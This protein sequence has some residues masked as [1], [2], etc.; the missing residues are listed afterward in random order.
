MQCSPPVKMHFRFSTQI[1][2]EESHRLSTV[3]G[4]LRA[5]LLLMGGLWDF[6]MGICVENRKC[7]LTCGQH[8]RLHFVPRKGFDDVP[9]T[10]Q[11]ISRRILTPDF[12]TGF[13]IDNKTDFGHAQLET[14]SGCHAHLPNLAESRYRACPPE[15]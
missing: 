15:V 10:S 6:P 4:I 7:I 2:M 1:P 8:C 5:Y 3:N 14:H 9:L 11:C 13:P 12:S